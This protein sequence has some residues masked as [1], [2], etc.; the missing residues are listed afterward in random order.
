MAVV[1][2][3]TGLLGAGKTTLIRHYCEHLAAQGKRYAIIE[4]EFGFAGV[5]AAFLDD[6][7]ARM[8]ELSGGC[9]CCTMKSGFVE[10]LIELSSQ[11]DHVIVEPSGVFTL[12]DFFE[13]ALAPAIQ[14][15]YEI[16][17]IATVLDASMRTLLAEDD[18][19]LFIAQLCGT[20]SVVVNRC[21]MLH[22]QTAI[23][24][25]IRCHTEAP[26]FLVDSPAAIPDFTA[27]QSCRPQAP[28]TIRADIS[29]A[30]IYQSTTMFPVHSYTIG[31][32]QAF[33]KQ[34]FSGAYGDVLRMKGYLHIQEGQTVYLNA[35]KSAIQIEVSPQTHES[36]IN[37]IGR[38]LL[39]RALQEVLS[40]PIIEL[41]S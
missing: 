25:E 37:I 30:T 9:L 14:A 16:G 6:C 1:D 34:A 7:G 17:I 39:R 3:F 10:M 2:L 26:V 21:S 8:K 5:D 41:D 27:M 15:S 23:L 22:P 18:T 13:V 40:I 4:N 36:M 35:T 29:H 28:V 33:A 24:A 38:R 20:G 11:V 31:H 19:A 32:I 12:G